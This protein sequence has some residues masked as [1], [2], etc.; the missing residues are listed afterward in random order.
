MRH[1]LLLA[2]VACRPSTS[3]APPPIVDATPDVVVASDAAP[4]DSGVALEPARDAGPFEVKFTGERN[5]WFAVPERKG[6]KRLIAMLHGVCN[7]PGY[8]CGH[9]WPSAIPHGFLVCPE[10]NAKCAWSCTDCRADRKDGPPSW[11]ES[12]LDID[13][14]LEK[15]IAKVSDL[16]PD[17]IERE[18]AVL[19]GFSRGAYVA[20]YSA[21]LHPGRWPY[22]VLNEADTEVT[23]NQLKAAK[24]KAVVLMAGGI[25]LNVKPVKKT[26]DELE[27][28]GF[29]AK[30]IVMPNAAHYYSNDIGDL[31]T[32][33]IQFFISQEGK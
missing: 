28:A 12:F 3:P 22:L 29:P 13:R 14:D 10:G 7:P 16:Y 2:C 23:A 33:A 5:V 9:W 26:F 1:L 31:M 27:K 4:E 17:E 24:V 8:A 11:E 18:G 25:G 19:V 32:E 20:V 21:Q 15:S 6:P 30:M